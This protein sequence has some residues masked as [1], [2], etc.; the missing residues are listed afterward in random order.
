MVLQEVTVASTEE[1]KISTPPSIFLTPN[2]IQLHQSIR[3]EIETMLELMG[4]EII[5]KDTFSVYNCH[6][7]S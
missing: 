6:L 1:V 5:Q 3:Y 2:V 4:E 7:Q